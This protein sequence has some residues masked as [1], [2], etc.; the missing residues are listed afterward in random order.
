MR[1]G[2]TFP[3][4]VTDS[5]GRNPQVVG[6]F[7]FDDHGTSD[8]RWLP[9]GRTVLLL[10]SN[11][12][13]ASGLFT[14]PTTGGA[15]RA[16]TNDPRNLGSPT[17]VAGREHRR[18]QRGAVRLPPRR[19]RVDAHRD[20]ACGRHGRAASDRRRR[21]QAGSFD[22]GA[23]FSPDGTQIA[24]SHGT[25]D[26]G[27]IQVVPTAGGA[28]THVAASGGSER[29]IDSCV[30][31]GRHEDRLRQRSVDLGDRAGRRHARGDRAQPGPDRTA[32]AS[33]G[34]ATGRSSPPRAPQASTSS[35][36][37]R[38]RAR[39]WR[40]LSRAPRTRRS[41]PTGRRSRSMPRHRPRSETSRRSW[42]RTRTARTSTFS[43]RCRST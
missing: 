26:S 41:H 16:L 38:R 23:S 39:G 5:H 14:V 15:A 8:L 17:L 42:S 3:V 13:G 2:V 10:T 11:G 24:F 20:R 34:L 33:R 37:G 28:R 29:R 12:C 43:V 18:L 22:S 36:S 31:A 19:G 35:R 32:A 30:V 1:P 4:L 21:R 9:D 40:S 7:P 6:R 25:F 27:T